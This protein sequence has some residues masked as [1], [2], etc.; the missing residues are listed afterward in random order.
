MRKPKSYNVSPTL[1][2]HSPP[3]FRQSVPLVTGSPVFELE[4][5]AASRRRVDYQAHMGK[6]FDAWCGLV[7]KPCGRLLV[8]VRLPRKPSSTTQ[9]PAGPD[10][11]NF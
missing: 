6:G 5:D 11:S 2:D 9:V 3:P 8:L 7:L 1:A 10:G 4:V